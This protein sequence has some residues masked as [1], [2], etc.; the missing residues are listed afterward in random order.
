MPSR[1]LDYGVLL[2]LRDDAPEMSEAEAAT[3]AT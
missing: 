2:I 3:V 1:T